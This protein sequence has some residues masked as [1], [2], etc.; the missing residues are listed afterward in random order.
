MAILSKKIVLFA[1][2]SIVALSASGN[3]AQAYT[4]SS[5]QDGS[6]AAGATTVTYGATTGVATGPATTFTTSLP[7]DVTLTSTGGAQIVNGAAGGLYADPYG[8]GAAN[9]LAVYTGGNATFTLNKP[10]TYFGLTWGSVD[11]YNYLTVNEVGGGSYTIDGSTVTSSGVPSR[12]ANGD[13]SAIGTYFVGI[14]DASGIKSVVLTSTGNSF[15]VGSVAVSAV[16]LPAA[17]PMF[18]VALVGIG[19]LARRRQANKAAS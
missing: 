5:V 7:A 2:L 12:T 10:S 1:G 14:G 4:L 13:Q 3:V 15:E 17:L 16:P 19:A 9:Y 6:A 11:S 18:G 8:N